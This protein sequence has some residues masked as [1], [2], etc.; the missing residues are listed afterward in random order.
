M[1]V[2]GPSIV[3]SATAV[4]QANQVNRPEPAGKAD[5]PNG[6]SFAERV[7]NAVNQVAD[8]QSQAAQAAK[9]F[10]VGKTNDIA[11][12]MVEQQVA[13]LGFQLTLNVRNKALNAYRD[14]MNMPV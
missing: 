7:G 3:Q 12:V 10:E 1:L 4:G 13:S 8:Q 5:K 11:A 6:P 9:D 2:S 14:I